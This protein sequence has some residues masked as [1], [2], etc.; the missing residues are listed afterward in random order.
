MI[1][2]VNT[3]GEYTFTVLPEAG[4][5]L[6]LRVD[7][8]IG[9]GH[10]VGGGTQA[11]LSEYPDGTIRV[12]P[13]EFSRSEGIWFCNTNGRAER[14]WVPI[15][16]SMRL[17]DCQ[18]WPPTRVL[19]ETS[20]TA[21]CQECH[22][23]QIKLGFDATARRYETTVTS[24]RI[25][26]ESCHGPGANH[27]AL[28]RAGHLGDSVNI[29]IRSFGTEE[30]D[31]SLEVCFQCHAAKGIIEPGYYPG[32]SLSSYYSLNLHLLAD[33]PFFE[34]G[35]IRSFAYQKNHLYSDCYLSGSMTCVDCHDPHDQSYRDI[36]GRRLQ[37]RFSNGQCLDCHASKAEDIARHTHHAPDSPGS[38]CVACHMP[39]LQQ[40]SVGT[41]VR[42]GRSDHTIPIPRPAFDEALGVEN[43]CHNCHQEL[44]S[45]RLQEQTDS[46]YGELKPHK[47][48]IVSLLRSDQFRDRPT[49][50]RGLLQPNVDHPPAQITAIGRFVNGYVRPDIDEPDSAIIGLL[51]A[52]SAHNDLDV[53][54]IS[55]ATL[56]LGYGERSIVRDFLDE[57]VAQLGAREAEVRARWV[58]ALV[59]FGEMYRARG[60]HTSA[61]A[62]HRKALTVAPNHAMALFSLATTY[63]HAEDY[64][65]AVTYFQRTIESRDASELNHWFVDPNVGLMFVNLGTALETAGRENVAAEAYWE[66]IE[67]DP[68]EAQAY[69]RLGSYHLRRGEF[70]KAIT[71]FRQTVT[72][73]PDH[74]PAYYLLAQA[75]QAIGD[76]D[77]AREAVERVLLLNPNDEAAQELLQEIRRAE[78][79]ASKSN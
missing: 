9:R 19:G 28:A 69:F 15:T 26:C 50:A 4:R 31:A 65:N 70:D 33:Q 21:N 27:V 79:R 66:A 43:A 40:P 18:D 23:S 59:L 2:S 1:P 57:Q 34:D 51:K 77:R 12:L 78:R 35:R 32:Y 8:V 52:L 10:M 3:Q 76:L 25:N 72:L 29:G 74:A 37:G 55:L 61:I 60:D 75:Y 62:A 53:R 49:A 38:Q 11:F 47:D 73:K 22:G 7:A 39:Y 17:A 48:I 36:Y 71:L 44:S 46:W 56:H 45:D 54:A 63:L 41:R 68:G 30:K 24:Y 64:T 16:A 5:E 58:G 42:Y 20:R 6:V 13:L 67:S 14:G